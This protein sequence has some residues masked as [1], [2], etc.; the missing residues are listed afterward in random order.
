MPRGAWWCRARRAPATWHPYPSTPALIRI[1]LGFRARILFLTDFRGQFWGSSGTQNGSCSISS[2]SYR[3]PIS[4]GIKFAWIEVRTRELWLP[5]VGVSELMLPIFQ[6]YRPCTD[7]ILRTEAVGRFLMPRG[8]LLIEIPA[9][10]EELLTVR[11]LRVVVEVNLLPKVLGS[12]TKLQR[13]GE[14]FCANVAS[15]I[16]CFV[17]NT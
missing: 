6:R 11:K 14:K 2:E 4:N 3:R 1:F 5:E 8:H 13:V 10:P 17:N 12:Q 9:W 15:Q 16:G 7:M